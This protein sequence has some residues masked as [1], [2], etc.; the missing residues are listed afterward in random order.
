M[1]A[2]VQGLASNA[3]SLNKT[4]QYGAFGVRS[5]GNS[6]VMS[7]EQALIN[8]S[9]GNPQMPGSFGSRVQEAAQLGNVLRTSAKEEK[10]YALTQKMQIRC[11]G[12]CSRSI[13]IIS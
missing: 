9:Q 4:I 1:A 3:Y 6:D 5:L 7:T 12:L 13:S 10:T 11:L 8:S 2:G